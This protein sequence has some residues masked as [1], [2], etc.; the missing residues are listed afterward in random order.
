MPT[1]SDTPIDGTAQDFEF[2]DDQTVLVEV[3]DEDGTR[4]KETYT[5]EVAE[6]LE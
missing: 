4:W 6:K 5:F 3:V 1:T 2:I